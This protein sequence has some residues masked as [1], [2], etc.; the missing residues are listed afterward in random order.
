MKKHLF[1]AFAMALI[2]CLLLSQTAFAAVLGDEIDGYSTA[3]TATAQLGRGVYW[4]G[5]DYRQENYIEY[6][7][8]EIVY[9]TVVYGS[10]LLNYGKFSTMAGLLEAQGKHVIAGINGD[11]YNTADY[12]PIGVVIVDGELISSDGGLGA[13]GFRADG[14]ALI[15][16][17][18]LEMAVTF[19]G[20]EFP[21]LSLNKARGEGGFALF[22]D[23]YSITNRARGDGIDVVLAWTEDEEASLTVNCQRRLRVEQVFESTG[24]FTLPEDRLVLSLSADAPEDLVQAA[25]ALAPGELVTVDIAADEAWAAVRC[26]VGSLYRLVEDGQVG[27]DLEK[28]AAPRSAL[29]VKADGT[30]VLYTVDGRQPGHS[31]GA[32]MEQV[33]QRLIELGCVDAGILDGGGSTSLNAIYLGEESLSQINMPSGGSQR[34]VTNYIMLVTEETPTDRAESLALYP[35]NSNLLVGASVSFT[36]KAADENG[37]AA[38]LPGEL[39]YS[40]SGPVGVVDASGVF[41][42]GAEG[43]GSVLVSGNAVRSAS[44]QVRVIQTPEEITAYDQKTGEELTA[45]VLQPGQ[46]LELTARAVWNHLPLLCDDLCFTWTVEGEIGAI[47]EEGHFTAAEEKAEGAIRITAGEL[48]LELP[49]EV[50]YPVWYFEDVADT[51]WFAP[52]VRYVAERGLFQGTAEYIFSPEEEMTRAM[53]AT[54]LYKFDGYPPINAAEQVFADTPLGQWYS[55]AVAWAAENAIVRGNGDGSFLPEDP[56]TREQMAMI[57]K[58]YADYAGIAGEFAGDLDRFG[59]VAAVSEYAREAIAWA[60]GAG[61]VGG[62]ENGLLDPQGTASR[63]QVAVLMQR[64]CALAQ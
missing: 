62:D 59:D 15:G 38:R 12:E 28:G 30:V 37:Y 21:L 14:T 61:L 34:S 35:L 6:S 40:V 10:K 11:Y 19:G 55:D 7:P 26:A 63:A 48:S 9:P 24:A 27:A 56:I 33:A 17:P 18:A 52:G 41:I 44:A 50:R 64:F 29:G 22:T 53:M 39:H 5:S 32:T 60:V 47:D 25:R 31:V 8:N 3:L 42:A 4:T 49:V 13:I 58:N 20:R 23:E 16:K 36:V 46:E 54:L 57:F 45:I 43:S 2:V 51:D 1:R